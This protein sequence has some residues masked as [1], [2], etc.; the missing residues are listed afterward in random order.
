MRRKIG[1][2]VWTGVCGVVLLWGGFAPG[3]PAPKPAVRDFSAGFRKLLKMGMPDVRQARYVR[4]TP[5]GRIGISILV[6][7]STMRRGNAWLL[8]EEK[9]GATRFLSTDDWTQVSYRRAK[10][11]AGA[12]GATAGPPR[13]AWKAVAL[14]ADI[15]RLLG[16]LRAVRDQRQKSNSRRNM[17]QGNLNLASILLFAATVYGNGQADAANQI[18]ALVFQL[19]PSPRLVLA[20]AVSLLDDARY[21][22]LVRAFKENRDWTAFHRGLTALLAAAGDAWRRAPAM[23]ALADRIAGNISAAKPL[24]FP[25]DFSGAEREIVRKMLVCKTLIPGNMLQSG[26]MRGWLLM[27]PAFLAFSPQN[28]PLLRFLALRWKLLPLLDRWLDDSTLMPQFT[29]RPPS[30]NFN[31][32]AALEE[33]Q[34]WQG[35]LGSASWLS[36]PE[37]TS[38]RKLAKVLLQALRPASRAG[39]FPGRSRFSTAAARNLIRTLQRMDARKLAFFYLDQGDPSIK[40]VALSFLLVEPTPSD[41][42][43]ISRAIADMIDQ[44]GIQLAAVVPLLR[45]M[46][47]KAPKSAAPLVDRLAKTA[48][49]NPQGRYLLS[50]VKGI[51][52][53]LKIRLNPRSKPASLGE[54]LARLAES[55]SMENN[56]AD[57]AMLAQAVRGMSRDQMLGVFLDSALK[58]GAGGAPKILSLYWICSMKLGDKSIP[59]MFS[60]GTVTWDTV[61]DRLRM[62]RSSQSP[63]AAPAPAPAADTAAAVARIRRFA[64]KFRKLQR[65]SGKNPGPSVGLF[66]FD[67][68][69]SAS[70]ADTV[71]MMVVIEAAGG[72]GPWMH[73]YG[74]AVSQLPDQGLGWARKAAAQLLDGKI[75]AL[76]PLP[77][78][79][80]VSPARRAA[81]LKKLAATPEAQF[82][83]AV[84]RLS[85]PEQLAVRDAVRKG[86]APGLEKRFAGLARTISTVTCQAP[87]PALV[88]QVEALKGKRCGLAQVKRLAALVRSG[89]ENGGMC[90]ASIEFRPLGA[91]LVFSAAAGASPGAFAGGD[92]RVKKAKLTA[93]L[94]LE[95]GMTTCQLPVK[96]TA[97]AGTPKP[98]LDAALD[99]GG[100]VSFGPA[101][102]KPAEFWKR[103][104]S[105]LS[106]ANVPA[107]GQV[108]LLFIGV[109]PN[110]KKAGN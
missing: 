98:D 104:A 6:R 71:A 82:A 42:R 66:G 31:D 34:K 68:G 35:V 8:R 94:M 74:Q 38:R 33:F 60:S 96:E 16:R 83:A 24:S 29:V 72:L 13:A 37:P 102:V 78:A 11:G 44:G 51:Q 58:A 101:G 25:K 9:N 56:A 41:I 99:T 20:G 61:F 55:K 75:D 107:P 88:R 92:A 45:K 52:K 103:V 80:A 84:A 109:K 4:L 90:S 106:G 69:S 73:N 12:P 67:F 87:V 65:L 105:F 22:E 32:P 89:F 18:A 14:D 49:K 91:A 23:R 100:D 63:A 19:A 7:G 15:K 2:I 10:S 97:A 48:E 76:P 28:E 81:L 26:Q 64:P 21:L 57:S 1:W 108:R 62:L 40:S 77:S 17:M 30:F 47:E 46:A 5:Q 53:M 54:I 93:M 43:A 27:P 70:L 86:R 50:Q 79:G 39:M 95:D 85:T 3:A 59:S 36:L 110:P